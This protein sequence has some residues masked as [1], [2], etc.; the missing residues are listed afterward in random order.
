MKK[1]KRNYPCP[2]A[3]RN[4]VFILVACEIKFFG[5]LKKDYNK[6]IWSL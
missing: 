6:S 5:E 2:N 3:R 4:L 1:K